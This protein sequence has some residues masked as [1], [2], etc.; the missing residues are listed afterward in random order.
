MDHF[1]RDLKLVPKDKGLLRFG[2]NWVKW[3]TLMVN[4]IFLILAYFGSR[5]KLCYN[6]SKSPFYPNRIPF[7]HDRRCSQKKEEILSAARKLDLSYRSI[8]SDHRRI[9]V[10]LC[11]HKEGI[12]ILIISCIGPARIPPVAFGLHFQRSSSP[13]SSGR[14]WTT[15]QLERTFSRKLARKEGFPRFSSILHRP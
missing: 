6:L 2:V 8:F 12:C 1:S 5:S 10:Y 9:S 7:F 3:A 4:L 15:V 11:I 13:W 14:D